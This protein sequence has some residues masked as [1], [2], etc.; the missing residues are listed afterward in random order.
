MS[1]LV[2][3]LSDQ[4]GCCLT[5][6]WQ[7][8]S[9][10]VGVTS[11]FRGRNPPQPPP[12]LPFLFSF[13]LLFSCHPSSPLCSP[14][15]LPFALPPPTPLFFGV[16]ASSTHAWNRAPGQT[17]V[18]QCPWSDLWLEASGSW[19]VAVDGP[20]TVGD[21]LRALS[22]CFGLYVSP[23]FSLKFSLH[24]AA[25]MPGIKLFVVS[26][27]SVCRLDCVALSQTGLAVSHVFLIKLFLRLAGAESRVKCRFYQAVRQL[28]WCAVDLKG[29]FWQLNWIFVPG[30]AP[31]MTKPMTEWIKGC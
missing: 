12:L 3:S 7:S 23:S 4:T 25:R 15:S 8:R 29:G 16:C 6:T 2:V 1:K 13:F 17:S 28:R 11:D 26:M 30:A 20:D 9:R 31:L 10:P 21:N 24:T 27:W 5:E 19:R 22:L 14:C 18:A